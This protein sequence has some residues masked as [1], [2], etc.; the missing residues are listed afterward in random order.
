[1]NTLTKSQI[2]KIRDYFAKQEDIMAVYLY[3]S[4][5]KGKVHKESDIDIAV[6]F[7]KPVDSYLR[8]GQLY[9]GFPDLGIPAEPEIRQISLDNSPVFLMNVISKSLIY[10]SEEIKRI[11]FEVA[12]MNL[13]RDTEHLRR[14]KYSYMDKRL[15]KGTYG[16]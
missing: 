2:K 1:M 11:R 10:T 8:L 15:N 6:V 13:F 4:F 9:S 12:V 14:L 7:N 16:Y 5:A 3:G